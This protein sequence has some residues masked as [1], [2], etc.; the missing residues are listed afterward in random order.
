MAFE[1]PG[2]AARRE[3]MAR[4]DDR[5]HRERNGECE[6]VEPLKGTIEHLIWLARMKITPEE[7]EARAEAM[8][9][10]LRQMDREAIERRR[11]GECGADTINYSHSF[12]CSWRGSGF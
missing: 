2:V 6:D 1:Q 3:R 10:R 8:R 11:C 4:R 9:E 7:R 12:T 5:W